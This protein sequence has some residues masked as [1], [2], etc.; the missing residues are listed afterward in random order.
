MRALEVSARITDELAARGLPPI[1]T[2]I[3]IHAGPAVVG[4]MGSTE[5]FDYTAIGDTVNLASRLEGAN[6][7]FGTRCLASETAWAMANGEVLG[8]E[9]GR[10]GVVGR[11][12]PIRVFEPLAL[13]ASAT[14][15]ELA[16]AEKWQAALRALAT[17][18]RGA[19]RA[20]LSTCA[21]LRPA[22]GLTR[23]W[24]ERLDDTAFDGEF[25]L[26]AK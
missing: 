26:D 18:D 10:I 7:A 12:A 3:G 15:A 19:C 13:R 25:R 8:R 17:G 2:R 4:N 24:L 5:R 22:D 14:A 9:V 1:Q 6:K 23:L 16:L 20:A 21:E 11:A